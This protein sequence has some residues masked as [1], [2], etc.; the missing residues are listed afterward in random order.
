MNMP[1]GRWEEGGCHCGAVRF[2]VRLREHRAIACNCSIC[3][4]KGFVNL[5]V[6]PEDFELLCGEDQL[7][8]YRFNTR[9]AEHR[10]CNVCGI[11]PFSR[12]RSHA[13]AY[14]IN[15]RCLDSGIEGWQID[16]F[17]GRNWEENVD[18][19]R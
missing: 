15:A 18:K 13:G 5:I 1:P 9:Q 7:S 12:P 6:A 4:R 11:H 3:A 2:R 8:S 16:V 10:F 19:I 14:D 17:D